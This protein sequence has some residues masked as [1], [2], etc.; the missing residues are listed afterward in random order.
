MPAIV[1]QPEIISRGHKLLEA[2]IFDRTLGLLFTDAERGG[3]WRLDETGVPQLL[4][5]HRRG[6]GGMAIHAAGGVVVSGRTVA[7]KPIPDGGTVALMQN[8]PAAGRIGYNDLVTDRSGR[9]YVGSMSFVPMLGQIETE[10]R[11]SLYLIGLD[12]AASEVARGI[13]LSNGLGF[14]A[15]GACLYHADSL[16]HC[17]YAYDVADDGSLSPPRVFVTTA[18]GM[19]DGLA[20]AEDGSVWVAMFQAG[21]VVA[22]NSK[23]MEIHRIWLPTPMVT[24]LCFGD[25]DN[26]S[27]YIVSASGGTDPEVGGCIYRMRLDVAGVERY[28]AKISLKVDHHASLSTA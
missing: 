1:S 4:I 14:S 12:G 17:V 18:E 24:S 13:R 22:Y 21:L 25:A 8:D 15:D 6:I 27:L 23:G 11:G 2:P 9:I 16:A 7:F 3:V 26:M 10:K 20:V 19:P 5:P 28:P